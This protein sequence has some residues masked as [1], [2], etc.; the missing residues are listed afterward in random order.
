MV[1]HFLMYTSS[2]CIIEMCFCNK[3]ASFS[4]NTLTVHTLID[5]VC[6]QLTPS[7]IL[8]PDRLCV[9]SVLCNHIM[10]ICVDTGDTQ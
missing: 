4:Q 8:V 3:N 5:S 7:L 1:L 10:V 6:Q 2:I 9:Y